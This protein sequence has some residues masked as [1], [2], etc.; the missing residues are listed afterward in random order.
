MAGSIVIVGA[1]LFSFASLLLYF[2][3]YRK[4]SASGLYTD[5]SLIDSSTPEGKILS[6]ARLSYHLMSMMVIV[7]STILWY[8][9]LTHQYQYK[10]V[11]S[12]SNNSLSTGFLISSFWGGQEGSF[13]LW[14]LLTCIVG[15]FLQSYTQKRGDL[16]PRVM[17]LFSL[18]TTF[19]LVMV[20]PLFKNPFE[21][22]WAHPIFLGAKEVN[23]VY[24][25][26]PLLQNYMFSDQGNPL[27]KLDQSLYQALSAAGISINSFISNGKGLNPQ[28]LNFWMQ[29]HPPILFIGFAMSTVPFA[30]AVAALIKNDYKDWIRQSL[31]WLLA[32]SGILGL[33]IML[34]GYWAYEMLGWGGYWAWDPVENSSLI[35]WL[36]GVAAIH[37]MLVQKKSMANG[38]I[39]RFA[40]TNIALSVMV[41]VLVL[42]STFLTRSGILGDASVHSFVDP[43]NLVYFFLV[44]FISTFIILGFGMLIYR[45][46]DLQQKIEEEENVLSRDLALFTAAVALCASASFILVGTSA[47]IFGRAVDISFY[48][49]VHLPLAI[50]IGLLN[51]FSLMLKWKKT[52][53][54][55]LAKTGILYGGVSLFIAIL[56]VVFGQITNILLILLTLS[57]AFTLVV[58]A[59]IAIKIIKGNK[60]M[61]GAYVAHIGI[62]LFILGVLGSAG[63]SD[64]HNVSL[65]KGKPQEVFGYKLTFTGLTPI[66]NDT[67]YSFNV[68]VE[69]GNDKYTARP[70]MYIS[71]FNNSLVREPDIISMMF[72]D[73]YFSPMGYENGTQGGGNKVT[74]QK[75]KSVDFE[76]MNLKF[77]EFVFPAETREAMMAGKDFE[78]KAH[79]SATT[80]GNSEQFELALKSV[81]GERE[82]TSHKTKEGVVIKLESLDASGNVVVTIDDGHG[83]AASSGKEVLVLAA[84]IKPFIIFVWIG[85]A[86]TVGGFFVAVFRRVKESHN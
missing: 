12:Y 37:T 85:V 24:F 72:K 3:S 40:K 79:L 60:K 62:A 16:E 34:G 42:Y 33:G 5:L 68:D 51:G 73:V 25:N 83:H 56:I 58:N 10:Y 1:L 23:P 43:G 82:L 29:I 84:S 13:M 7:A 21:Y 55:D 26:L 46:K 57:A 48:N 69:K 11:Y 80:N 65:E 22:I 64:E 74:I 76:E 38:G 52:K 14:L 30:F 15:V 70:V 39:G 47:P 81:N 4:I 50:L 6:Y 86:V 20:S 53:K 59:D 36:V 28:L 2:I 66:E 67:K 8:L 71:D 35:P 45:R 32:C 75:G 77:D 27:I 49:D 61:L 41:Y 44:V 54:E 17:M 18:S 63:F 78:I 9:L 19:L 31:P